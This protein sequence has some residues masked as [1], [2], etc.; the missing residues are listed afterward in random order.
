MAHIDP[1]MLESRKPFGRMRRLLSS[2][3]GRVFCRIAQPRLTTVLS[4]AIMDRPSRPCSKLPIRV[5]LALAWTWAYDFTKSKL[6]L[7]GELSSLRNETFI[8]WRH[9]AREILRTLF[10]NARPMGGPGEVIQIDESYFRG[11]NVRLC[12]PSSD[13]TLLRGRRSGRMNGQHMRPRASTDTS[14]RP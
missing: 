12:C 2:Q 10:A 6:M 9:F 14:T 7:A 4:L 13:G 3:F 1:D 8:D 5:I 11:G